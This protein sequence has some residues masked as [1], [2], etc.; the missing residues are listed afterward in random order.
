[1]SIKSMKD[2]NYVCP[3]CKQQLTPTTNGLLCQRDRVEYPIKNG[4][5]DFITEDLTKTT[6]PVLRSVGKLDNFAKIYEGPSWYGIIDKI[7]A[8]LG[9]PLIEEMATMMTEM[10]DAKDG[11]GLDVAVSVVE[12]R[13]SRPS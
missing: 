4:I 5:V 11:V 13:L 10:V 7:N 9:L 2:N 8:E 3:V 6:S 12:S 1:M